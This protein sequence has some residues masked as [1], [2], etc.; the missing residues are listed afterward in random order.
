MLLSYKGDRRPNW[1]Q[2]RSGAMD[3][4]RPHAIL[5]EMTSQF[6][7]QTFVLE[8]KMILEE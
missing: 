3:N 6:S 5:L 8:S 4:D 7:L 2:S 1:Y